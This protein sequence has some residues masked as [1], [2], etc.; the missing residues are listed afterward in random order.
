MRVQGKYLGVSP[1]WRPILWDTR[2]IISCQRY[3]PRE[4]MGAEGAQ[5]STSTK[6]NILGA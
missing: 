2:G 6:T 4:S 1:Y 3:R 5:L